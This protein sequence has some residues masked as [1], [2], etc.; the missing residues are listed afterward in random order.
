ML[1]ASGDVTEISQRYDDSCALNTNC[2]IELRVPEDMK[3]P[4]YFYYQL[5]NFYQNHR[6]YVNSRSFAQL[7]GEDSSSSNLED[8]EP[9]KTRDGKTINPCGL[10]ASSYFTDTFE[11]AINGLPIAWK[12]DGIAWD[13]DVDQLFKEPKGGLK[14]DETNVVVQNGVEVTLPSVEDEQ[15]MVWM[16]TAGLPNFRKLHRIVPNTDFKKGQVIQ[17]TVSNRYDTSSFDG[18][19]RIVFSTTSWI[20]GKNDFLGITYIVVG[21]IALLLA[22]GFTAKHLTNPRT[23]GDL[24]FIDSDE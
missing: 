3:S 6:R 1:A 21:G 10:I 17:V 13:S 16:R 4:I 11:A 5:T 12:V 20:G 8:C 19:K 22:A 7:R 2:T 15:F 18:E 24:A 9:Q 23:L 14:S